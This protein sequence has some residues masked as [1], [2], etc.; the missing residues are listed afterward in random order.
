[1]PTE[2]HDYTHRDIWVALTGLTGRIENLLGVVSRME[3]KLEGEDGLF[4]RQHKLETQMAQVR[5]VGSLAV[6]LL[7]FAIT[8]VVL[9]IGSHF[10]QTSLAIP[11]AIERQE[12]GK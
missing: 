8:G 7:P 10:L 9:A 4:A 12:D 11:A 1:M 2:E 5:L 6:L 3:Q